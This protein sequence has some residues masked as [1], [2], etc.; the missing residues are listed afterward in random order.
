M[1]IYKIKKTVDVNV[2]IKELL[3]T[4][5]DETV[6]VLQFYRRATFLLA[7]KLKASI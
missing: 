7:R 6:P 3:T 5:N 2:D 4:D 1:P